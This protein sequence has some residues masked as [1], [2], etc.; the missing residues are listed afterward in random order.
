MR[1]HARLVAEHPPGLAPLLR[2]PGFG[3][4]TVRTVA[5]TL[6]ARDLDDVERAAREGRLADAIG[7]RRASDLTALLPRLRHPVRELRLKSAWEIASDLVDLL[8]DS[9]A[10][11]EQIEVAGA[12]RR[13]CELVS[14]GLDL[15]AVP[16]A[17]GGAALLDL[18]VALPSVV[19]VEHREAST[20]EVRLY[21]GVQVRVHLTTRA[22]LGTS[23]VQH[24]GSAAHVRR[25][26]RL[27]EAASEAE[28]YRRLDLP[29]I[30]PELREDSGE[31][32][33]PQSGCLPRPVQQSGLG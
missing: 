14:D 20:A 12:A 4:A 23:L 7:P 9:D 33:A 21:D 17:A 6:G 26:G 10:A 24:T 8:R 27:P 29:W 28:V 16:G 3:P 18:L 2:A 22:Q 30:A 11:P 1:T 13:M 25:L 19:E 5:E 15:V 32:E 31:S